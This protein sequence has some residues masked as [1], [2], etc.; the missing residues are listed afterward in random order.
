M[1]SIELHNKSKLSVHEE[2]TLKATDDELLNYQRFMEDSFTQYI[3]YTKNEL[4]A[5]S[6]W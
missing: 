5:E 6:Y 3:Q 2:I 4:K 1:L